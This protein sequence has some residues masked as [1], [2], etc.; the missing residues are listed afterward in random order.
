MFWEVVYE[1][2]RFLLASH[3]SKGR[4]ILDVATVMRTAW[5]RADKTPKYIISDAMPAYPDDIERVFDAYSKNIQ[6]GGFILCNH[7]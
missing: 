4:T 7:P 3:L 5:R 6:S 1:G 2:T